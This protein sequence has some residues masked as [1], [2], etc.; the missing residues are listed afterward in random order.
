M[1]C[2]MAVEWPHTG[3]ISVEFQHEIAWVGSVSGLYQLCVSPRWIDRVGRAIP[4]AYA[5]GYD[6]E[7]VA[8][9][10]HWMGD[11]VHVVVQHNADGAVGTKVVDIRLGRVG[12]IPLVGE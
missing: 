9:K 10:M 4:Y 8:V 1:P 3:I 2:D 12:F 11:K 7:I 5:F 6:P